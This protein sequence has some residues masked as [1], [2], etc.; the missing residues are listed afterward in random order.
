VLGATYDKIRIR[1]KTLHNGQKFGM[2]IKTR[3]PEDA[4]RWKDFWHKTF[5]GWRFK[6]VPHLVDS[7]VDIS[8]R[9][10][11]RRLGESR[12]RVLLDNSVIGHSITHETGWVSTGDKKWGE[13]D[14]PTGYAARIC[15]YG[16]SSDS[17]IYKNV[18]FL[19]GISHLAKKEFLNFFT[20]NELEEEQSRQP[21]GRYTG[22][23]YFDYSLL[24]GIHPEM[25]DER[26][27]STI[28]PIGM[29]FPGCKEQ[30]QMRLN[31]YND[32]LYI[33]LVEKLGKKNNLDAWHIC[34]AERHGL[35]CF[36]TMDLKLK[37]NFDSHAHKE[38]I[39]SLKTRLMTPSDLGAFLGLMPIAPKLF[40][41]HG[42][43]WFVRPDLHW[44][45]NR[46]RPINSYRSSK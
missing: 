2:V 5:E 42:A 46:R 29:G 7:L 34:T 6:Y 27:W 32:P 20:S 28:G 30:Q 19:P 38:P 9:K 4:M 16:P 31:N 11:R 8:T 17:E 1:N 21:S 40:S 23:G 26:I 3:R 22:Y 43:S 10:A 25:I 18:A 35:F 37:R 15:V 12:L 33:A 24:Q 39:R 44:P 14:V 36:L 13:L 41:Y 45:D